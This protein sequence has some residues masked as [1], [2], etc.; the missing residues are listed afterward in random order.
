MA[1]AFRF[2]PNIRQQIN[3]YKLSAPNGNAAQW[4]QY[5]YH[6]DGKIKFSQNKLDDKFDRGNLYDYTG[7]LSEAYSGIEARNFLNQVSN[8][9]ATLA[10]PYRKNYTHNVW[11]DLTINSGG[12]WSNITTTA[13][14]IA[15]TNGRRSGWQYDAAGNLLAVDMVNNN[16][17][18]AA[19][20]NTL[21]RAQ[22]APQFDIT[23]EL[24][25]DGQ[26]VRWHHYNVDVG[27]FYYLRSSV[28]GGK[29]VTEI[30]GETNS[31]WILGSKAKSYV[32][33]GGEV[34]AEQR[35]AYPGSIKT[36]VW[37]HADPAGSD[38]SSQVGAVTSLE[39]EFDPMGA[40]VGFVDPA[41]VPVPYVPDPP[42]PTYLG[43][44]NM[45]NA[46]CLLDGVE[47]DCATIIN[48]LSHG[49]SAI[50]PPQAYTPVTATYSNGTS[51]RIGFAK[52]NSNNNSYEATLPYQ[53]YQDER[54]RSL[55]LTWA[56]DDVRYFLPTTDPQIGKAQNPQ[57]LPEPLSDLPK[58]SPNPTCDI[59][60]AALFGGVGAF[61][62]GSG[63]EPQGLTHPR[64]GI[65]EEWTPHVYANLHMYANITGTK[66]DSPIGL[67]VPLDGKTRPTPFS[68]EKN[69]PGDASYGINYS[70]L[71]NLSNVTLVIS[72]VA[73]YK[74]R[75]ENGRLRLGN[76]GGPGGNPEPKYFHS[77][78]AIL[79]GGKKY[80]FSEVFCK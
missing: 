76:I 3:E 33:A 16:T 38:V 27:T 1:L 73:D 11:G 26:V 63:Y 77:H 65:A 22:N 55:P 62:A 9:P 12:Y 57:P 78:L 29:I 59:K 75:I 6:A 47:F 37:M 4:S 80:S 74:P 25:G 61:A 20:R 21:I 71:G 58:Q 14:T 45:G 34:L 31:Y 5:Q 28:L 66:P 40:D 13:T 49:S 50:A 32:Y 69:A 36:V 56:F 41:T 42:V 44:G 70:R 67:Y 15:F 60:L 48:L 10:V 7:R 19:S 30:H 68:R 17:F 24:D 54:D 72:H 18:D 64:P 8:N 39:H 51:K 2:P 46:V 53:D 43:G 35:V 52:W 79:K 23:Q